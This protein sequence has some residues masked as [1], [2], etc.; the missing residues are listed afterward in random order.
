MST[1]T[2]PLLCIMSVVKVMSSSLKTFGKV[3]DIAR[4][5]FI[6]ELFSCEPSSEDIPRKQARLGSN[7]SLDVQQNTTSVE[8]ANSEKLAFVLFQ[9]LRDSRWEVKDST[10]EF[11]ASLLRVN[12]G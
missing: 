4:P 11:V 1:D 2:N 10:L 12:H 5:D 8:A 9:R 7:V 6:A 3:L